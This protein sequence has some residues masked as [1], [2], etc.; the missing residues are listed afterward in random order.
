MHHQTRLPTGDYESGTDLGVFDD[1]TLDFALTYFR[2]ER[3]GE[4]TLSIK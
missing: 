1:E 4:L 3:H 2:Y